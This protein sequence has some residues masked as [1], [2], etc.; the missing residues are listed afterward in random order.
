MLFLGDSLTEGLGVNEFQ[1]FPRLIEKKLKV[2]NHDVFIIN[3]GI[4][5]S[6]SASGV[7]R[8]NWHAKRN[9]DILVLELGANDGLRGLKITETEM[10]LKKI[11]NL[12]KN[13]KI[14]VVLLGLLMPPNYGKTY[15]QDFERMYRS[16]AKS[17]QIQFF[18][19]LLQDVAGLPQYNQADGIHPNAKGHELIALKLADFLEKNL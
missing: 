19:S 8:L 10:N 7:S 13:K 16:I 4:S 3:G 9:I 5:G 12:A 14:K 2:K 17:E 6:T 1:S 15:T 18:P 11:V